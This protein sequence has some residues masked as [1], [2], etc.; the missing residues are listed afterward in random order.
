MRWQ[1]EGALSPL[2]L[3][4]I[5]PV[6]AAAGVSL[7]LLTPYSPTEQ[8]LR[9]LESDDIVSV[10]TSRWLVFTPQEKDVQ[11]GL[12]LYPGGR[13]DEKA[14]AV[15][16]RSIAEAGYKTV[17]VQM[18]FGLAVLNPSAARDVIQEFPDIGEWYIGGHS[19]GG[20]MAARFAYLNIESISGLVLM[21]SYPAGNNDLSGVDF[22][23]LSIYASLDGVIDQENLENS[24][25]LLPP[26]TVWVEI[27]GGNHAQF[28]HYGAQRGDLEPKISLE[29][30][31]KQT[32]TVILKFLE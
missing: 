16:A 12:I 8:A 7:W 5:I 22:P 18:P 13:V 30:Q 14:Y 17:I 26:D 20:A 21:A 24:R 15:L 11:T 2:W 6:I 9:A 23:V 32:I 19:L 10:D 28:G 29:E 25:N 3:L 1:K 31:M 4:L 27:E